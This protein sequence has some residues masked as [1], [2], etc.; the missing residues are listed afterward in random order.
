M[1]LTSTY[2]PTVASVI[3]MIMKE[4]YD[5]I[6]NTIEFTQNG[7]KFKYRFYIKNENQYESIKEEL[8][9]TILPLLIELKN[10]KK[11][12]SRFK[13]ISEDT[14]TVIIMRLNIN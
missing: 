7:Q 12:L 3:K 4:I 13:I 14:T 6:E 10:L 9:K 8:H 11:T 5:G 1:K 2:S